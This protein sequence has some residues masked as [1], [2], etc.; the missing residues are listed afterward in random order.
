METE[1]DYYELLGLEITASADDI[2]KA[3]RKRALKVHPD[4]NPSPDA[5]K[6]YTTFLVLTPSLTI[7]HSCSISQLDSGTGF[8]VGSY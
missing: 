1:V 8:T 2:K 5:G 4:K 3:Y 6:R 7:Y